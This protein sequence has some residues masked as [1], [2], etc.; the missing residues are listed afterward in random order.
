MASIKGTID[1]WFKG[2]SDDP[3]IQ[4]MQSYVLSI[5]NDVFSSLKRVI[6][7][8]NTED[9]TTDGNNFRI[10]RFLY[11]N[12]KLYALGQVSSADTNAKIYEKASN[13]I[14]DAWTASGNGGDTSGGASSAAFDASVFIQYKGFFYWPSIGTRISAY[15]PAGAGAMHGAGGA[16]ASITYTN[17]ACAIVANDLLLI[18][19]DNKVAVKDGGS[20]YN[21]NWE[22]ARLTLPSN[23]AIK[24]MEQ[25]GSLVAITC[26]PTNDNENNSVVFLWDTVSPDV[27]EV[28]DI[29]EGNGLLAANLGGELYALIK[30]TGNSGF[31][32]NLILR[33]YIGGKTSE[34]V[35]T[36]PTESTINEPTHGIS[37]TKVRESDRV[38]FV[39][40]TTIDGTAR[41]N[42]WTIGR[43]K[44]GYPVAITM[45]QEIAQAT[46]PTT[47]EGMF[48]MGSYWFFAYNAGTAGTVVRTNNDNAYTST[49]T[50]I[51][52]KINGEEKAMGASKYRKQL[53]A[54]AMNMPPLPTGSTISLY[55]RVDATTSWTKIFDLTTANTLVKMAGTYSDGTDFS[56]GY[57]H[58]FKV[59]TTGGTALPA[60]W[61]SIEYNMDILDADISE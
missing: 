42:Q 18:A 52:Q 26:S 12:N 4:D 37:C 54:I 34:I 11:Y 47:V 33:R 2:M 14:T 36:I 23:Y 35:A 59:E 46:Q 20:S 16:A 49:S 15:D 32:N 6:P 3:R 25:Y 13:N 44:G 50:F 8:R 55:H 41:F 30:T 31:T 38:S 5:H 51:T 1:A 24:D 17:A 21:D 61:S 57:E 45:A 39:L 48:K 53:K 60:E 19:Y 43:K 28:I 27:T 40:Q 7:F 10:R 29:G 56:N 58:Q 9:N 22:S